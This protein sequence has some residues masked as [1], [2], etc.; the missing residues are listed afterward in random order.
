[1]IDSRRVSRN[2][3]SL[4]AA[5]VSAVA[6]YGSAAATHC[7]DVPCGDVD[8]SGSLVVSDALRLLQRIVGMDRELVCPARCGVSTSTTTTTM[9][10]PS[11]TLGVR[12]CTVTFRLLSDES[13]DGLQFDVDY[14][15]ADGAL[16]GDDV[17]VCRVFPAIGGTI[18]HH[19]ERT[20]LSM[21]MYDIQG[22]GE[23]NGPADII[24]CDYQGLPPTADQFAIEFVDALRTGDDLGAAGSGVC[25]S[26]VTGLDRPTFRDVFYTFRAA[27]GWPCSQCECD[28]LGDGNVQSSDAAAIMEATLE[29]HPADFDCPPCGY[30]PFLRGANAPVALGVS[31]IDC[32]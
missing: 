24:E 20:R 14:S 7:A 12:S 4:V 25:G 26:P 22:G 13:L 3:V 16:V 2:T 6:L 9:G 10:S 32:Q 19:P 11:T 27:L 1:M 30:G 31:D 23:V 8:G 15:A 28:V 21:L 17:S 18:A 29:V 5:L